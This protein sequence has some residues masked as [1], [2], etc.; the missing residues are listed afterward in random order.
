MNST[1]AT[2][3]QVLCIGVNEGPGGA[4]L[5]FAEK[6]AVDICKVFTGALGPPGL[7]G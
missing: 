3:Y 2:N 4:T 6:D 7:E 5:K 1:Y